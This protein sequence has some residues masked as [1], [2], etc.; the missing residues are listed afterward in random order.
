[1]DEARLRRART[2]RK[3]RLQMEAWDSHN[4][5]ATRVADLYRD[6]EHR[7]RLL[8]SL[9]SKLRDSP[10]A[11]DGLCLIAEDHVHAD[12]PMPRELQRWLVDVATARAPRPRREP[13]PNEARNDA[14]GHCVLELVM[15]GLN[16]TRSVP[17]G[18]NIPAG[19]AGAGDSACDVAGQEFGL[20]YKA[21][22]AIWTKS[23]YHQPWVR[24]FLESVEVLTDKDMEIG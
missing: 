19:V 16:A 12:E 3:L 20:G 5:R 24:E 18:K 1:M 13:Y 2:A 22:E 15:D 17:R 9:I 4:A 10:W 23:Y 14:I 11:W 8:G 6:G 7:D 21:T